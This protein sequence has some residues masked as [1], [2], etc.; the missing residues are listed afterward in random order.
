MRKA[1][2]LTTKRN[3]PYGQPNIVKDGLDRVTDYDYNAQGNLIKVT[4]PD[5]THEDY[6]Y[7]TFGRL[8]KATDAA[9]H[10]GEL[11]YD[12]WDRPYKS[13][14]EDASYAQIDVDPG[15]LVTSLRDKMA[16]VTTFAYDQTGQLLSRTSPRVDPVSLLH[17]TDTYEYDSHG[18]LVKWTNGRGKAVNYTRAARGELWKVTYPAG[19]SGQEVYRYLPTGELAQRKN[20]LNQAIDYLRNGVGG[21]T[22]VDY[23]TG[24]TDT[25]VTYDSDGNV[26]TVVDASGTTTWTR[27]LAGRTTQLAQPGGTVNTGYDAAGARVSSEEVGFGTSTWAYNATTGRLD[28]KTNGYS[29]TTSFHYDGY[30]RVDYLTLAS[31]AKEHYA[32]DSMGRVQSIILKNSGG[33]AL[34]SHVYDYLADGRIWKDTLDG[35]ATT[36]TYDE[37]GQLL[38]ESRG[39]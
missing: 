28:S 12:S 27:D 20:G 9:G 14:A 8:K 38:S 22:K 24:T 11:L 39:E 1:F 4:S 16:K 33:T 32:F 5:G 6:E 3:R 21:L 34:R 26:A 31:G 23:P 17:Y 13:L 7:T 15:G 35:V 37:E 36:Y 25:T 30:G 2:R 29:E 10:Y 18:S 19:T